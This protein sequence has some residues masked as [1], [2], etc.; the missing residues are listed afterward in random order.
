[1]PRWRAATEAIDGTAGSL[2]NLTTESISWSEEATVAITAAELSQARSY[3]NLQKKLAI[4]AEAAE[5][6]AERQAKAAQKA[7]DAAIAAAERQ[8]RETARIQEDYARQQA[9][10]TT[11]QRR[12]GGGGGG[13]TD[14]ES[15]IGSTNRIA[16][17]QAELARRR[18][19]LPGL[20]GQD[21]TA[22]L[23][24]IGILE[25]KL[26]LEGAKQRAT[27]TAPGLAAGGIIPATA[28][29]RIVRAGEAGQSEVI[30]PLSKLPDMM[31][32]MMG[33]GNGG[34]PQIT[35][36]GDVYGWDDWVDKVGE[37]NIEIEERGG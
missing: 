20:S 14:H 35:I 3:D 1:M 23:R 10:L 15:I 22:V 16:H 4:L 34:R 29:G 2:R 25:R 19:S 26:A 6:S 13:G 28:G 17:L 33:G 30:I 9:K 24:I 5:E 37:A 21:L 8:A 7:A 27:A 12:E 31:S 32:R 36:M 11:S 18:A